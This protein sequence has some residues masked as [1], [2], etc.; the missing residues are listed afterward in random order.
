[1]NKFNVKRKQGSAKTRRL[2]GQLKRKQA[3]KRTQH[4]RQTLQVSGKRTGKSKRKAVQ[5]NKLDAKSKPA[6]QRDGDGDVEMH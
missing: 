3:G 5:Q 1:M 2:K 6:A 4:Q